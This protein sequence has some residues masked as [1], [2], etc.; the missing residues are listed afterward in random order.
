MRELKFRA[1]DVKHE[2]MFF[3]DTM[4]FQTNNDVFRV[5]KNVTEPE[6]GL[7]IDSKNGILMQYMGLKDRNGT[8]IYEGD[9]VAKFDLNDPDFR[10]E[11]VFR[12][13]AFGYV[14]EDQGFISFAGNS[15]FH[16]VDRTSQKVE[17]VGNIYENLKDNVENAR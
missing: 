1:W 6:G 14:H 12:N 11:V 15:H 17:V 8:D 9:I 13:G 4:A 16:W 10:S 7:L 5:W 2:E 3:V